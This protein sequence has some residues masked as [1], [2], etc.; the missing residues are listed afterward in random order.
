M[1]LFLPLVFVVGSVSGATAGLIGFGIGS[2][3]TPLIS[4]RVGMETAVLAVAIPHLA[5][6]GFRMIRHRHHVSWPVFKRF[7]IWSALGGGIGAWS[8]RWLGGAGVEAVLG[9][10]LLATSAANLSG[11]FFGWRPRALR[12]LGW[13]SGFFGGVAGNQGGL[14]AAALMTCALDPRSFLATSTA[15]AL[16]VDLVR[17]PIYLARGYEQLAGLGSAIAVAS[18]G[19]LAGTLLGERI[20]F[21]LPVEHYRKV[22]AAAVGLLGVTIL[23]RAL[24]R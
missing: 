17:T 14:R 1:D 22:V 13:F 18:A 15:I 24:V 3:L 8:H 7:G 5:A 19:C 4:A 6:T 9:L 16:V 20:L 23:V 21:G 2:L 10:L 12:T 11:G